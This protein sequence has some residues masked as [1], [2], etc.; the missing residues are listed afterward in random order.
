MKINPVR[1]AGSGAPPTGVST[2]VD[3]PPLAPPK[4]P[5]AFL[6]LWFVIPLALVLFAEVTGLPHRL[7]A[8]AERI[9]QPILPF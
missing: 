4:K 2:P 7:S 9:V 3:R 1:A 6:I 5:I 8:V